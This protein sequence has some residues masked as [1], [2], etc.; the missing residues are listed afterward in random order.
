MNLRLTR[1]L[2][3]LTWCPYC[4]SLPQIAQ[5]LAMRHLPIGVLKKADD[6][7]KA[8]PRT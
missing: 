3:W 6:A 7:Q 2:A 4:G 8:N 1:F 5:R